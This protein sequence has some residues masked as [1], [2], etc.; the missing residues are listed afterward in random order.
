MT[1]LMRNGPWRLSRLTA[2]GFLLLASGAAAS[3]AA[4]LPRQTAGN[5]EPNEKPSAP[6]AQPKVGVR[7]MHAPGSAVAQTPV[8]RGV[9]NTGKSRVPPVTLRDPNM[10]PEEAIRRIH[11]RAA[12]LLAMPGGH[13]AGS[14]GVI[15][16]FIE[17]PGSPTPQTPPQAGGRPGVRVMPG[18]SGNG[19]VFENETVNPGYWPPEGGPGMGEGIKNCL[20]PFFARNW[21]S[22]SRGFVDTSNLWQ[23]VPLPAGAPDVDGDGEPDNPLPSNPVIIY[24][25]FLEEPMTE[26][27]WESGEDNFN[28]VGLR[29]QDTNDDGVIDINDDPDE[30]DGMADTWN[31]DGGVIVRSIIPPPDPNAQVE[32]ELAAALLAMGL[33]QIP[34]ADE[35]PVFI[36]PDAEAAYYLAQREYAGTAGFTFEDTFST[37]QVP[38]PEEMRPVL[39]AAMQAIS[40]VCN[41]VFIKRA[42]DGSNFA[43]G[44]PFAPTGYPYDPSVTLVNSGSFSG[45]PPGDTTYFPGDDYPWILI[46]QGSDDRVGSGGNNFATRLGMNRG[47]GF[48]IG[49]QV[50]GGPIFTDDLNDDGFPDLVDL[51]GDGI[52]DQIILSD[53]S[54]S[55]QNPGRTVLDANNDNAVTAADTS[56]ARIPGGPGVIPWFDLN[57]DGTPDFLLDPNTN[58][59]DAIVDLF[60]FLGSAPLGIDL[61]ISTNINGLGDLVADNVTG[62]GPPSPPPVGIKPLPCELLNISAPSIAV[63]V[64]EF[65]HHMGFIHEHQRPDRDEFV[66]INFENILSDDISQFT[67]QAGGTDRYAN[68]V[69]NFDTT[70]AN[71]VWTVAGAPAS[72]AWTI[73]NPVNAGLGDPPLDFAV[74]EDD[75]SLLCAVTGNGVGESLVGETILIS[76]QVFGPKDSKIEFAYWLNSTGPA[77]VPAGDGLFVEISGDGGTTW[78]EVWSTRDTSDEWRVQPLFITGEQESNTFLVRFIARGNNTDGVVVEA[79]IDRFR[80]Q[81]EYDFRSIMHY[82]E[83]AFSFN[84]LPVI[85]TLS[86]YRDFQNQL[87]QGFGL[88]AGDRAALMNLYGRKPPPPDLVG[89]DDPCRA[90]VSGDGLINTQDIIVFLEWYNAGDLRADF[91]PPAGVID[92][93]DLVQFFIDFQNAFRCLPELPPNILGGNNLL[94]LDPL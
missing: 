13:L 88:S 82:G 57:G 6:A 43:A 84:G 73:A 15:G 10:S 12:E 86:S 33:G 34:W 29:T 61:G 39:F 54:R 69:D 3:L 66:Q 74:D 41:V 31:V 14:D 53:I 28:L 85:E 44:Y 11:A 46:V 1:K 21:P 62:S 48:P 37:G 75:L 51:D 9:V 42:N 23:S 77:Q 36:H 64:H 63:A 18:N 4:D 83:F 58:G 94:P 27:S 24:Y 19:S 20:T 22:D 79:G 70:Q 80:V 59:N 50:D 71:G 2:A 8:R 90:D 67:K 52:S 65:M 68:Y 30:T 47:P 55:L 32:P 7:T 91:A 49:Y 89:P 16:A 45:G 5:A 40:E 35:R 72:G 56:F 60:G 87:G 93:L 25:Q 26:I 92:F 78:E 81:N 76:P 38:D 17:R